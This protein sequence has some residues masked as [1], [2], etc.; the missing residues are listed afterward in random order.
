MK[1]SR[2]IAVML[3]ICSTA[4]A[5]QIASIDVFTIEGLEYSLESQ[6]LQLQA[7]TPVTVHRVD[8]IYKFQQK[9]SAGLPNDE[10]QAMIAVQERLG[11][12]S[13][14]EIQRIYGKTIDDITLARQL[15]V[16]KVPA[17]VFNKK[18]IVYGV[19]PMRAYEIY[20]QKRMAAQLN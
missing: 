8:T 12:I 20:D 3:L 7:N 17:V 9:L 1:L 16:E 5:D 11:T 19:D 6:R 18:Y 2:A 10:S 14:E 13:K 15:G 4:H